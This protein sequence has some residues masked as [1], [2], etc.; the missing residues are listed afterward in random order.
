MQVL[1]SHMWRVVVVKLIAGSSTSAA[2]SSHAA[3]TLERIREYNLGLCYSVVRSHII[4]LT[5]PELTT[6]ASGRWWAL[7]YRTII[8]SNSWWRRDDG[9]QHDIHEAGCTNDRT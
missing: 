8:N 9:V 1:T 3:A 4:F 2:A 6:W 7:S 5:Y